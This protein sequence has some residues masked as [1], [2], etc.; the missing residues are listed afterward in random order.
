MIEIVTLFLALVHG[1]QTVELDVSAEVAA[2]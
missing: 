2:V 1:I